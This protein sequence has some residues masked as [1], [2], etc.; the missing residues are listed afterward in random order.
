MPGLREL[1]LRINALII[2]LVIS[3]LIS[4]GTKEP[5]QAA[6]CTQIVEAWTYTIINC[7]STCQGKYWYNYFYYR[8]VDD[9]CGCYPGV[10]QYTITFA[11]YD[12][13]LEDCG[14]PGSPPGSYKRTIEVEN[15]SIC[16]THIV[17]N[18][19]ECPS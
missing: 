8:N 9:P 14:V 19:G 6:N 13:C 5:A 2:I 17:C 1:N 15:L 16:L 10:T 18:V 7:T 4:V 11:W 12:T 3:L